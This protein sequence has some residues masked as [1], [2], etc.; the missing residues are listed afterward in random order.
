[1]L[2]RFT[3]KTFIIGLVAFLGWHSYGFAQQNRVNKKLIHEGNEQYKKQLYSDAEAAYKKVLE[4]D[5][6]NQVANFNL[7]N[8]LYE[9][10]RFDDARNQYTNAAKFAQNATQAA[11]ASYNVG[12]TFM[13]NQKWK[14]SIEAYKEA[15]RKN[16]H[17]ED[18]RY[19]LAYAKEKLKQQQQ[20]QQNKDNKD[21]KDDKKN[22]DQQ[23]KDN[24]DN[25][26]KKDQDKK[27]QK[28][29]DQQKKDQ[30]NKDQQDQNK[31][32]DKKDGQKEK[33][34]PMPSKLSEKEAKQLLQALQQEEKK[35]QDEKLK[36]VKGRPVPM[37]K[38]W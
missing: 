5:A 33:P 30:Q 4:K 29:K 31:D 13:S 27:D 15:L 10:K 9:Q 3:T 17:D 6:K 12:N 38:D 2:Q 36:K 21:N 1:M 23:N 37:Q 16:P 32:Q 20:Q 11:N 28:D 14:E 19:N 18:A 24:K 25:K 22:K 26:D 34:Q 8:S 35:L 7:G